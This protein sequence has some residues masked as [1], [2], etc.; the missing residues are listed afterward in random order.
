[1]LRAFL[2]WRYL[3][4]TSQ[5]DQWIVVKMDVNEDDHPDGVEIL[6]SK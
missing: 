1:M 3:D 6:D 4:A 2:K 5:Q